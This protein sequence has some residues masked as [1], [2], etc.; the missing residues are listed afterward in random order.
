LPRAARLSCAWLILA[1]LPILSLADPQGLRYRANADKPFDEVLDDLKVAISEHNFRLTGESRIG[2]AIAEREHIP[3]PRAT[4]LH[5][6]NLEYARRLLQIDP[7][8]LLHMPCRVTAYQQTDGV[9]VSTRL[10]PQDD[11]RTL[12]INQEINRI[13]RAIVDEAL[14]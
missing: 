12:A 13:L 9:R 4:A 2:R 11:P 10:L 8:Y 5:F 6:C 14:E 7:A 1:L 3:F